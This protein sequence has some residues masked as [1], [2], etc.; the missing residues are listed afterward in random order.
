M[1][2][3]S[4]NWRDRFFGLNLSW[5]IN[6]DWFGRLRRAQRVFAYQVWQFQLCERDSL[7]YDRVHVRLR[8]PHYVQ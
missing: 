2:W 6:D 3:I 1:R 8:T 4:S 5:P 7:Q